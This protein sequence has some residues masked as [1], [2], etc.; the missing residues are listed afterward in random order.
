MSVSKVMKPRGSKRH[1]LTSQDGVRLCMFRR[2]VSN[3]KAAARSQSAKGSNTHVSVL[4]FDVAVSYP[5]ETDF[6]GKGSTS[7][8]SARMFQSARSEPRALS[9]DVWKH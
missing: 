2:L 1:A 4:Q 3:A 6:E 8:A 7:K 5:V 9:K